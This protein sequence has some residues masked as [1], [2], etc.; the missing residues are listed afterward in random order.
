MRAA[1]LRTVGEPLV[2]EEVELEGPRAGEVRL[3]IAASGICGSDLSNANGT[4][5]TPL[6]VVLGHEAAGEVL[7]TGAGVD[8]L[9]RGHR[10]V[11]SLSPECGECIFCREGKPH[12]CVQ[13]MPG[14]LH[15][16]LVDGTTRVRV[17]DEA[18]H[19]LCGVGSFA[20]EAV[21]CA[22]SC[23][24]VPDDLPLE[25][26]CLLGCGVLTGAGAALNTARL[27]PGMCVAVIGC[28]GVGLSAIQ[29][30]RIAGAD[31]IIAIDVDPAKLDL[32]R[33]LGASH[34]VDG[35]GD[36]VAQVRAIEGLGVHA[37]IEAIGKT[38][39]IETAWA[40]LRPGGLAVV[41][42]MP[43]ARE[44]VRLRVG[45]FFQEKRISGCV[46]GS[47]HAHRDIPRLMELARRG[48][49]RLDP[50]VSE[51]LPLE[52]VQEAMD[53][54]ARGEGARHVVVNRARP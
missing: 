47:A 24:R 10:V 25:R 16:T 27:E 48:E 21:V 36:V 23:I 34:A 7:E 1:V 22:R 20:E 53:C 37:A 42:G 13:M 43:A 38:E 40:M 12:F 28:G 33:D 5:R 50:L 9:A 26:V 18:I 44:Q 2:I 54:L 3:R 29:G 15:S 11:V 45:G 14:M 35:R 49:L 32:A 4:L 39:T 6:P 46:Y 19:Q 41:I 52:R 31:K 51:E 17:G 30:A 8:D